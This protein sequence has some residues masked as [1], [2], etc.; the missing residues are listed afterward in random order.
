MRA[1][2]RERLT[3]GILLFDGGMGTELYR[4]GVF[5]NKCYDE[6][7]V[8]NP[9]LVE[10]VH[11]DYRE[12]GADVLETNTY[13]ANPTRLTAHGLGH[14]VH[15]INKRGAEI[16]RA[17]AGDDLYVAASMGPLGVQMEPLGPLSREEAQALFEQQVRPL[18]EGGVDLF[19]LETFIYPEE[20]EQA[21]K[22]IR[23]RKSVV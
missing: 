12:A 7:N 5:I 9:A 2:I 19:V 6:L 11:R 20:L 15:E 1:P 18:I 8:S 10:Q 13:G 21:I 23:D 3:S 17:V 22:A 4:R 14:L 16:A